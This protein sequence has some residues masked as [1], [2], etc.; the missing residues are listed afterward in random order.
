MSKTALVTGGTRGIGFG[1][2]RALAQEGWTLA[3]GGV[4][5][6]SDVR[7]ALEGLRAIGSIVHYLRGD[8]ADRTDRVRVADEARTAL[9]PINA[10]VNNAGRPSCVRADLLEAD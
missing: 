3:V 4:R 10:L 7:A 6:E 1:I 5:P 8:L 2:A 9:G